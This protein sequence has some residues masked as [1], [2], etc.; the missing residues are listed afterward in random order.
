MHPEPGSMFERSLV[1]RKKRQLNVRAGTRE[2]VR[3]LPHKRVNLSV[4]KWS[5]FVRANTAP[6]LPNRPLPS[7][8]RKPGAQVF[9]CRRRK[10]VQPLVAPESKLNGICAKAGRALAGHP[11]NGREQ[12][13]APSTGNR[14][15]RR[16]IA[17]CR[18]KRMRRR[19]NGVEQIDRVLPRKQR[20]PGNGIVRHQSR[21][22]EDCMWPLSRH[23]V[24]AGKL[25]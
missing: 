21:R 22:G 11:A 5:T 18:D 2:K 4:K 15:Q 8:C 7:G 25:A 19:G 24:V 1:C 9:R 16:R 12:S 13:N 17:P 6:D 23:A 14:I 20:G 3:R 10:M